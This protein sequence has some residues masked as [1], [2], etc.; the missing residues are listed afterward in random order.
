MRVYRVPSFYRRRDHTAAEIVRY[1]TE[2][3]GN[4]IHVSDEILA[5]LEEVNGDD[6]MWAC[7]HPHD[8]ERYGVP[9]MYA[10]SDTSRVIGT[11]GGG[12]FL[13]WIRD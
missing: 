6:V 4:N 10:I 11:D 7:F 5:R 13:I 3:L 9:L 8:A 12:G 1:E 2:E